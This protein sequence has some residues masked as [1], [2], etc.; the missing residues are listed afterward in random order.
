MVYKRGE[1]GISDVENTATYLYQ[2]SYSFILIFIATTLF[3]P[4]FTLKGNSTRNERNIMS[5]IF[6]VVIFGGIFALSFISID[7]REKSLILIYSVSFVSVVLSIYSYIVY[8]RS[9]KL[10]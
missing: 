9:E 3:Q 10:W 4:F 1:F 7:V 6:L 5:S 2:L 8:L